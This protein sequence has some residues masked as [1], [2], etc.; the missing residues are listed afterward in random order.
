MQSN[1]YLKLVYECSVSINIEEIVSDLACGVTMEDVLDVSFHEGA[2]FIKH[3]YEGQIKVT[4]R[5]IDVDI[6]DIKPYSMLPD[7]QEIVDGSTG[8]P[9]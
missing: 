4:K 5:L 8:K 2:I 3:F 7:H 1:V 9:V 6:S